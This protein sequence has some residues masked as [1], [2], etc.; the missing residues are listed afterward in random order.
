MLAGNVLTE[1]LFK[2]MECFQNKCRIFHLRSAGRHSSLLN[3]ESVRLGEDRPIEA[4]WMVSAPDCCFRGWLHLK[5]DLRLV[6]QL[7]GWLYH[8]IV[9]LRTRGSVRRLTE[10]Q[11]VSGR[12]DLLVLSLALEVVYSF[13]QQL[14]VWGCRRVA[15]QANVRPA[16][17]FLG[18]KPNLASRQHFSPCTG[19]VEPVWL[20]V[21][22]WLRHLFRHKDRVRSCLVCCVAKN[23]FCRQHWGLCFTC[24]KKRW[25]LVFSHLEQDV[26]RVIIFVL[27][28]NHDHGWFLRV[29]N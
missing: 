13:R 21:A 17:T 22:Y 12:T 16:A 28:L 15:V 11:L 25:V 27:S 10:L 19:N 23:I 20:V 2:L 26:P 14:S 4:V 7:E 6:D 8:N 9:A 24:S 1:C 18:V 5:T 3:S 29:H